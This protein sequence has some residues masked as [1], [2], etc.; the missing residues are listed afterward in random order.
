MAEMAIEKRTM[1][2][3]YCDTDRGGRD[4]AAY[5]T[6]AEAHDKELHKISALARAGSVRCSA[7]EASQPITPESILIAMAGI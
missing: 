2:Q 7:R 5:G 6:M 3:L 4:A 1:T